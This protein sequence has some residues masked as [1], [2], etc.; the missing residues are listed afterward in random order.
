VG[1]AG[2]ALARKRRQRGDEL[3]DGPETSGRLLFEGSHEHA[4]ELYRYVTP[5]Q[6]RPWNR[7][8]DDGRDAS[9]RDLVNEWG[10]TTQ[11]FVQRNPE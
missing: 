3:V 10:S 11:Q 8:D 7:V 9:L 2:F 4:L 6:P 5:E 1:T